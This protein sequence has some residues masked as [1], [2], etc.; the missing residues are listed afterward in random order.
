[1]RALLLVLVGCSSDPV[2][3]ATD[4]GK[5]ADADTSTYE[6]GGPCT[7]NRDCATPDRCECVDG[8]C[9]CKPG[10]RGSGKNG[11]DTCASGNDCASSICVDGSDGK[12]Y[13]SDECT[14]NASCATALPRCL[15][16][17]GLGRIC[18]R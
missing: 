9:A 10:A 15:D 11:V 7:F 17:A 18:V 5:I 14:T 13:C 16:V 8:T 3:P 1:M 2:V 12:Q 6:T 4:A